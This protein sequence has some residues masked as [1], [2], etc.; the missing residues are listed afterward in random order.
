[1]CVDVLY[2]S[3][4]WILKGVLRALSSVSLRGPCLLDSRGTAGQNPGISQ[5]LG[6]TLYIPNFTLI[7]DLVSDLGVTSGLFGEV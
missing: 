6:L 5:V 3:E 7:S 2:K 1:M 4:A